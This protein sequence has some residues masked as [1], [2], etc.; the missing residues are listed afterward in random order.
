VLDLKEHQATIALFDL[1]Y[2]P[3]IDGFSGT[4]KIDLVSL[5]AAGGMQDQPARVMQDLTMLEDVARDELRE[6][7]ED[8]R[9]KKNSDHGGSGTRNQDQ[10]E[11]PYSGRV[12]EG[13]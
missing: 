2:K 8:Y 4:P 7:L 10:R 6:D 3:A 1:C 9:R 12:R 5:P 13:S 11:E